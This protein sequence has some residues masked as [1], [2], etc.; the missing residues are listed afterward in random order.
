[1]KT[2][3]IIQGMIYD[4]YPSG[5][6]LSRTGKRLDFSSSSNLPNGFQNCQQ[7]VEQL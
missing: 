5:F 6:D 7:F 1:M 3:I 4:I 2:R